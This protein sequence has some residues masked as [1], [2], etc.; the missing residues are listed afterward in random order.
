[1]TTH[2]SIG[3]SGTRLTEVKHR[4]RLDDGPVE[5]RAPRNNYTDGNSKII[6][7]RNNRTKTVMNLKS[8]GFGPS[9]M[10]CDESMPKLTDLQKQL[11]S[12]M[13]R[14]S[15]LS[16]ILLN[17]W[18]QKRGHSP[19]EVMRVLAGFLKGQEIAGLNS[20]AFWVLYAEGRRIAGLL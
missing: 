2:E 10:H 3:R 15:P 16:T 11:I 6:R 19:A 4:V 7:Q 1:M 13:D 18:I 17:A 8:T 14:E 5:D 12:F 20:K 9:K